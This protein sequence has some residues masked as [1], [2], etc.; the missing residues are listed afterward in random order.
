MTAD[1][2]FFKAVIANAH[3][4]N[5]E[6]GTQSATQKE[7]GTYMIIKDDTMSHTVF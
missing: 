6:Y 4:L 1:F 5:K 3:F 7:D 2:S